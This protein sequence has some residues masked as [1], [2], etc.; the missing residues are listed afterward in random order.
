MGVSELELVELRK[1][2]DC[3]ASKRIRHK[4]IFGTQR[5]KCASARR[6]A[7]LDDAAKV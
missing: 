1:H 5:L 6:A 7:V 2:A 4:A 3:I